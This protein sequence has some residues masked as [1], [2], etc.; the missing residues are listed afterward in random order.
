MMLCVRACR[1]GSGF[2]A[3]PGGFE[4][5]DGTVFAAINATYISGSLDPTI[6]T[7]LDNLPYILDGR[8]L[9]MGASFSDTMWC[10][11][12]RDLNALPAVATVAAAYAGLR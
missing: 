4:P 5:I 11:Y 9:E 12:D 2:T 1:C 3:P 7:L 10:M 6:D 8:I